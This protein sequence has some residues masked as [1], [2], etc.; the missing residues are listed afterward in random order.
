M[1]VGSEQLEE[2]S[3][4]RAGHLQ[5]NPGA[6]WEEQAADIQASEAM[7]W[8]SSGDWQGVYNAGC[9]WRSHWFHC[10]QGLV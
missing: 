4:Q 9:N 2:D 3:G 7:G 6:C 5:S 10:K 1:A 8:K